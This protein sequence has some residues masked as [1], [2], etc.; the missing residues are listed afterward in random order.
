MTTS[1]A[2]PIDGPV[3]LDTPPIRGHYRDLSRIFATLSVRRLHAENEVIGTRASTSSLLKN[4]F[5]EIG[6]A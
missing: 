5:H 1:A 3:L 4:L 6:E 2:H